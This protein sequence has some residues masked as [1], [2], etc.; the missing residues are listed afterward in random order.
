[1]GEMQVVQTEM[2]LLECSF[3]KKPVAVKIPFVNGDEDD[4]LGEI[5]YE[6]LIGIFMSTRT[7]SIPEI[8]SPYI[9]KIGS[10]PRTDL[11]RLRPDHLSNKKFF[12]RQPVIIQEFIPGITLGDRLELANENDMKKLLNTI[13]LGFAKLQEQIS[14]LA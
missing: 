7:A 3:N 6:C 8:N 9:Y 10:I 4:L 12:K 2:N 13:F 1:M 5:F 14:F 11:E